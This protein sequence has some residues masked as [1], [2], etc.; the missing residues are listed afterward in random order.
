[1]H[2]HLLGIGG[3]FMTGL[4]RLAIESGYRVTGS[5][6]NLYP[7][8][9]YQ[10]DEL[11]IE[12]HEGYD[13]RALQPAPDLVV[14]GNALSRGNECLEYVL[15]ERLPHVSGPAW[16]KDNILRRRHVIA[17]AG[18]HGKTTVASLLIWMLEHARFDPGFLVGG[19]P[20]NFEV[21]ARLGSDKIFV[22]EADEYDTAF[23]DKRSKFIHYMPSMLIITNL[24]FDHADIFP[25]L[26]AIEHQFHHLVR[27]LP[28]D[29]LIIRRWPDPAIDRVLDMGCWSRVMTFGK[30]ELAEWKLAL[31]HRQDWLKIVSPDGVPTLAITKLLGEHNAWNTVAAVAAASEV[32]VKPKTSLAALSTFKNVKRRLELRGIRHG[33]KVFD[34]FAHHPTAYAATIAALRSEAKHSRIFAIVELRSNTM[35][36]GVHQDR[37]A[38]SLRDADVIAVFMP[39]N[40]AWDIEK[41]L[42]PLSQCGFYLRTDT[43]ITE[44]AAQVHTGDSVL[45][46]SNGSFDNIHQR[47]LDFLG[48]SS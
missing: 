40:L 12:V 41:S 48:R 34:D 27:T 29:A 32:G 9:S 28:R 31:T 13:I 20:E 10:L 44:I 43:L 36:M 38:D 7:P 19:V 25:D 42:A 1:V 47:F 46:M 22:I 30:D 39:D 26:D 11:G 4:A 8:M 2:L 18:T 6:A 14:V 37:L 5:D 15:S 16:L 3:T 45:I 21:S 17:V 35:R 33:V 23:D 24:E